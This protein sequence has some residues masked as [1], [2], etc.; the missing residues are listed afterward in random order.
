MHGFLIFLL[1]VLTIALL[2]T[3]V[4]LLKNLYLKKFVTK[5][6]NSFIYA[7]QSLNTAKNTLKKADVLQRTRKNDY[8][9]TYLQLQKLYG[10]LEVCFEKMQDTVA[11]INNLARKYKCLKTLKNR[12]HFNQINQ[13]FL[14][15]FNSFNQIAND[16]QIPWTIIDEDFSNILDVSQHLL[17]FVENKNY[18][19]PYS[20]KRY[21][22]KILDFRKELNTVEKAKLNAEFDNANDKINVLKSEIKDLI[23]DINSLEKIEHCLYKNLPDVLHKKANSAN[24]SPA[25]RKYYA[26]L[27]KDLIEMIRN[28]NEFTNEQIIG[29]M[30]SIYQM[31][32]NMH[33]DSYKKVLLAKF[34]EQNQELIK[35]ILEDFKTKYQ[36]LKNP[37]RKLQ[38]TYEH[39]LRL[40]GTLQN[41]DNF[42]TTYTN[43]KYFKTLLKAF[44]REYLYTI[45]KNTL[46]SKELQAKTEEIQDSINIYF[47]ALTNDFLDNSNETIHLVNEL[48]NLYETQIANPISREELEKHLDKWNSYLINLIQKIS[49]NEQ[50]FKMYKVLEAHISNSNKYKNKLNE[51]KNVLSTANNDLL[52]KRYKEAFITL[53]TYMN[54]N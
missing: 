40:Y 41:Y 43:L 47:L 23:L 46:K 15:D 13:K 6:K 32:Y 9:K 30:R 36:N 53:K 19:I 37:N 22:N 20:Y 1:V 48:K 7:Q 50:Y 12:D 35:G 25:A 27:Y 39:I 42:E 34:N 38:D 14:N 33:Y 31:I 11:E 24:L 54:K 21:R 17:R 28:R 29:R 8:Q 52:S 4:V 10:D 2:V 49:E 3:L 18:N 45:Q 51:V 5:V 44:N 16:F 26:N